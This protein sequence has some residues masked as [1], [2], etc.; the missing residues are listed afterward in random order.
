MLGGDALQRSRVVAWREGLGLVG[1][2]LAAVVGNLL[3]VP[4]MLAL[5]WLTLV[6]GWWAW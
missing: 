4:V 3:G 1:V 5:L 2:V 6:L